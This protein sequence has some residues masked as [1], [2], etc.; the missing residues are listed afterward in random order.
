MEGQ[1]MQSIM[2]WS[3]SGRITCLIVRLALGGAMLEAGLDKLISG[4]FSVVGYLEHGSGPFAS[5]FSTLVGEAAA[6]DYLVIWGEILIGTA[7]ILGILVRFTSFWG[8]VMMLL[9][10][11]PYLPPSN[12]WISEQIIYLLVFVMFMF[13]G[14]GYY[15][16]LDRLFIRF[17]EES[18][19]LRFLLG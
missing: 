14:I 13:T 7:L 2:H 11:L 8:A 17:E 1:G 5:W 19:P 9:Y 4:D 3:T 12:G 15:W 16:G 18:H 10:Y 6:L